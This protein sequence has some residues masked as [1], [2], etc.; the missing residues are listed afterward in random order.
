MRVAASCSSTQTATRLRV[1]G[2]GGVQDV[3]AG[4]VAVV[5]LEAELGGGLDHLDV[6]VDDRDAEAAGEQRLADHLADAAEADDEHVAGQV[7]RL[8]D[9]VGRDGARRAQAVV[10]DD[11]ERR[12]DHRDDDDA[13]RMPFSSGVSR[14]TATAA[15]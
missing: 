13:V 3:E 12:R 10:Q 14:P 1:G 15:A 9:A 8:V 2:A 11:D 5:D 6:G 7:V 4:A